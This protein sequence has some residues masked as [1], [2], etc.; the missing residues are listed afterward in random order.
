M[1]KLVLVLAT[2]TLSTLAFSG[3]IGSRFEKTLAG[4]GQYRLLEIFNNDMRVTNSWANGHNDT[5]C[6]HTLFTSNINGAEQGFYQYECEEDGSGT[7]SALRI[8][9]TDAPGSSVRTDKVFDLDHC[10]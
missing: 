5:V 8:W 7:Y 1:K 4:C 3:D 9:I 2:V 6:T 10:R